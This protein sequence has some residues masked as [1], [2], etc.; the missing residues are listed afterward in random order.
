MPLFKG[1]KNIGR[2]ISTEVAAG[3]PLRVARAIAMRTAYGPKRAK[4]R[5]I[6][7]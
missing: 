4:P 1:V 6:K 7:R 3:K 5:R 2:N